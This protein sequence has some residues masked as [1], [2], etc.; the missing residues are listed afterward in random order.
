MKNQQSSLKLRN[1]MSLDDSVRLTAM[2]LEFIVSQSNST[3]KSNVSMYSKEEKR[4][5][6]QYLSEYDKSIK[7][8]VFSPDLKS[9]FEVMADVYIKNAKHPLDNQYTTYKYISIGGVFAG[10]LFLSLPL[11]G[12]SA[13]AY[14]LFEILRRSVNNLETRGFR[15]DL[16]QIRGFTPFV[17]QKAV[18]ALHNKTSNYQRSEKLYG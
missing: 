2:G 10:C 8:N 9:A 4:A 5:A 13:G 15:Q 6:R 17:W 16:Q 18:T 11:I 3:L 1:S 14:C 12:I 7:E